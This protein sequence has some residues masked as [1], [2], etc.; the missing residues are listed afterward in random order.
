MVV[1]GQEVSAIAATPLV[2]VKPA[3][4]R[5]YREPDLKRAV[6]PSCLVRPP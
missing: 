6:T 4:L 3:T 1:E 2:R 5:R